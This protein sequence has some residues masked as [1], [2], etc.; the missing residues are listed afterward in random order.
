MGR[1]TGLDPRSREYRVPSKKIFT[2][3]IAEKPQRAQRESIVGT[4]HREEDFN[5]RVAEKSRGE[6]RETHNHSGT[7]EHRGADHQENLRSGR[8][9]S[10]CWEGTFP[11]TTMKTQRV[12]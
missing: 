11:V 12:R 1:R 9:V 4:E 10:G 7:E 6:C 3:K 2:A 5:R 8:R